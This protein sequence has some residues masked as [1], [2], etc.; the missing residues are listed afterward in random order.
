MRP[1][2]PLQNEGYILIT[3]E[4]GT[5]SERSSCYEENALEYF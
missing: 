4:K 5:L 2:L 1:D 3:D